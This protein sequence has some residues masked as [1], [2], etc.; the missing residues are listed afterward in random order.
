MIYL[1]IGQSSD[2]IRKKLQKIGEKE[3]IGKLLDMAWMVYQNKEPK[4]SNTEDRNDCHNCNGCKCQ[5]SKKVS[6]E[7]ASKVPR[8][9]TSLPLD[10]NQCAFCKTKGH[11]KKECP[12]LGKKK[13]PDPAPELPVNVE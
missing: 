10:K 1:F 2:N 5:H 6:Q 3:D 7:K 13:L 8:K 9:G 4:D 12:V 11:W